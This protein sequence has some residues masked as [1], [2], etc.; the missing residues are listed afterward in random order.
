MR[1]YQIVAVL[2]VHA[3]TLVILAVFM[4][5]LVVTSFMAA[6]VAAIAY[7]LAQVAFWYVFITFLTWLSPLLYPILTVESHKHVPPEF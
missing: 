2:V 4:D 3:I 7:T 5:G 1:F 6:L